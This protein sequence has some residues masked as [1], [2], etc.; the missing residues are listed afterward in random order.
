MIHRIIR[1]VAAATLL[2]A[3]VGLCQP[4][5]S[6]APPDGESKHLFWIIP[7]YRTSPSLTDYKPLTV[8]EKFTVAAQ[9]SWDR[10]TLALAA[11][12]GA[13]NQLTNSN[14]AF[15][16]GAAGYG[17]YLG[18][19]YGD[20]VIGNYM[21]EAVFPSLLHQDPRYFRRGT[22][23]AWSRVGYAVGQ[24]FW[25]HNDSGHRQFNYSEWLGNSASV[26]ISNAYYADNRSAKDNV[27]QL[28]VQIGVDAAAN[29]LK[30]FYPDILRKFKH[31]QQ[32]TG[33]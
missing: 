2:T 18:A 23:N 28:G 14:R 27:S 5:T 26:A 21:T 6:E 33:H 32:Q 22:G 16:Q 31:K 3:S 25:T 24:T 4:S 11:V 7:N 20:F 29:I 1:S 15:G 19:A 12:F 10:G 13:E 30:E 8:R 17:R 9:D